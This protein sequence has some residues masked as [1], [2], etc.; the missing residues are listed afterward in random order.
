MEHRLGSDGGTERVPFYVV[1]ALNYLWR[2]KVVRPAKTNWLKPAVGIAVWLCAVAGPLTQNAPAFG[3]Q[4]DK[5]CWPLR[6]SDDGRSFT[7]AD[8][9]PFFPVIDTV[10]MLSYLSPSASAVR[11]QIGPR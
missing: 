6:V 9:S 10:W 3:D 5:D 2:S 11:Q 4:A 8:G 7:H 1:V